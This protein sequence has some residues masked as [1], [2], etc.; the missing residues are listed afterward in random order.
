MNTIE[1]EGQLNQAA[2]LL[3]QRLGQPPAWGM[4]LGSGL[5]DFVD[6]LAQRRS[7][8]YAEIP[9]FP[10]S[11]VV[12]HSGR[13]TLAEA[14]GVSFC[15]LQ[16]RVHLYEG[17]PAWQVVA[18]VRTLACWGVRRFVVTNAAGAIN[19]D[20]TPGDLMLIT[21]HINLLGDNPLCGPNLDSFGERF[22]DMTRAYRP[23]L[24]EAA[25]R[26]ASQIGLKLREGVYVAVLGPSYETP[27]EIRMLRTLGADAVGMSTV[28]E[29]I[30]LNH[31]GC[32][33]LGISCITNMAAGILDEPMRHED[34]LATTSRVR[35]DFASLLFEL[36]R[37]A[38]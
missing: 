15:A 9:G 28:P 3:R 31:A 1:L 12:G 18:A 16:G 20:F 2:E 34:V 38:K 29:V 10:V 11:T 30:A 6:Q 33:V 5:G 27:A 13:L 17:V 22:P 8:P 23:K 32:S 25:R 36:L 19:T 24:I 26:A 7:I 37:G 4:I 21:D 14:E 35:K